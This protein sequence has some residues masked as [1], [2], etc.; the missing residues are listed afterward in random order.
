LNDIP[1]QALDELAQ[2]GFDWIWL[3]GIWQTGHKS[4]L[5][6][7][8]IPELQQEFKELLPDFTEN[9]VVGSCFAVADY[10]VH[11]DFGGEHALNNLHK[12]LHVRGIKLMLDFVPNHT[13]H[14]HP[15]V[16][17][18]PEFYLSGSEEDLQQEPDN[19]IRIYTPHG[20]QILAYGRDPN[21][22]G[23]T[24]TL[25]L[26]Y[27]NPSLQTELIKLLTKIAGCCDGVRCDMAM[28][29]LPEVFER[30]WKVKTE[31]FWPKAIS[32]VKEQYADFVFL[33]EVYW[34][35]EWTL[36]EQGFDYCYD[37]RLYDLLR[38]GQILDTHKYLKAGKYFPNRL[39]RFI[40]NHDEL[41]AAMVFRLD[42]HRA[43]AIITFL[44]P[45]L[46]LFHQGQLEGYTK[47]I[48]A[49]LC[50][51]P[52]EQTDP[53][54]SEFYKRLLVCLKD[55]TVKNGEWQ[56][57]ECTSAWE[58][59]WTVANFIAYSWT[60]P[61]NPCWLVVVNYTPYQ[62]QCYIRL[63]FPELSQQSW[64]I[65]DLMGEQ[66]HQRDGKE[67]DHKGLYLDMLPWGFHV[68]SFHK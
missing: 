29:V 63:N 35:L 10:T 16:Q 54:L 55:K 11:E 43:A 26:N 49:Q 37:K 27:S 66:N 31:S 64:R 33:A 19:Y 5:I 12:R 36:Q 24:D 23:W 1:D 44:L 50:R 9:D 21:F 8:S 30:T 22:S 42:E 15:W 68:F 7:R 56:L 47:R 51:G 18:H 6:A 46:R 38:S 40:E 62:S 58:G 13:A 25:Q 20:E 32:K 39:V 61:E 17:Q 3:L 45:G 34:D 67:L 57:L 14:D 53:I 52:E 4:Q 59:N 2:L 65:T 41:R 60:N 48:P 28:L